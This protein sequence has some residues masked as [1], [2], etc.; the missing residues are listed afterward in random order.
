M[1]GTNRTAIIT[2]KLYWPNGLT[3][4]LIKERVYFADAHLDYIE[5]CDYFGQKR[6]QILANNLALHH[7][8]GLAF[9]EHSIF[10]VDRGHQ[11]LV[12]IN[13]YDATTNMTFVTDLSPQALNVK[14]AHQLAQPYEENPC[15]KS[16][17]EHLC[18]L[19]RD[20]A[21]GFKCMCQ[22]GYIKDQMLDY[23]CNLDQSEF[24]IGWLVF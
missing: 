3:L 8:H 7:P 12:K 1:D 15:E 22:I 16:T 10:W 6:T 2:S 23:R 18:L 5:S 14:V 4:D 20:S 24:L 17:C 13:R 21:M 9:F 19:S 11:R